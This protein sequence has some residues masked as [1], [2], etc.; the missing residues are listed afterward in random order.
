M[1]KF[2]YFSNNGA[3]TN[4]NSTTKKTIYIY[5]SDGAVRKGLVVVAP[6]GRVARKRQPKG[7]W[8]NILNA[9][10]KMNKFKGLA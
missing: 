6:R 8:G 1:I 3:S 9:R 4:Q 2:Y 7:Y 10:C 5:K